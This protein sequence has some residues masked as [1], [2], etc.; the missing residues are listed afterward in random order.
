MTASPYVL[1]TCR[2]VKPSGCAHALPLPDDFE[3]RL[4]A[5]LEAAPAPPGVSTIGRPIRHHERFRLAVCACPN[6]CVRPHVADLGLIAAA[7]PVVS[8]AD[9]TG[10]GAC[11]AACPDAALSLRGGLATVDTTRCLGC[12]ACVAACPRDALAA[13][14]VGLRALLG[15][16]LGRRPRLG[17]ELAGRLSPEAALLL[18]GRAAQVY[19][20]GMRP[21]ARF[22][23][24]VFPGGLPGL[25]VWAAAS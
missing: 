24:I 23:D 19:S 11:L 18:A 10:C 20:D 21:G 6:G 12:R 13:A 25:P 5:L 22:A 14:P 2:G 15:G 16:R 17:L 7:M 9:C 3:S 8:T 1:E 4:V